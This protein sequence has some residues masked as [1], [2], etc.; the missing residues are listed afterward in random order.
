MRQI[1]PASLAMLSQSQGIEPVTLVRV[2]WTNTGSILYG[3]RKYEQVGVT[4]RLLEVGNLEDVINLTKNATTTSLS[5]KIDDTDGQLKSIMDQVDI[6]KRTVYVYQWFAGLPLSEAFVIFEGEINT[7]IV[8]KEGE[9]SLSFDVL[10]KIEYEEVGFSAEEGDFEYIPPNIIGEAWP[11]PF[12]TC[13]K[14]KSLQI[15]S[16]VSSNKSTSTDVSLSSNTDETMQS[17]LDKA[18]LCFYAALGCYEQAFQ[19]AD[20]GGVSVFNPIQAFDDEVKNNATALRDQWN[21]AGDNYTDQGNQYIAK[22]AEIGRN[23]SSGGDNSVEVSNGWSY[24]QGSDQQVTING[25][26]FTGQFSGNTFTVHG[27]NNSFATDAGLLAGPMTLSAGDVA[28]EFASNV[29]AQNLFYVIGSDSDT[30]YYVVSLFH[31]SVLGVYAQYNGITTSVPSEYY[32]ITPVTLGSIQAT[33]LTMNT[34]LS[35]ID[36]KWSDDIYCT[37]VSPVGPNAVD[38]IQYL[39]FKYSGYNIDPVTF[40]GVRA[41]L[42]AYPVNFAIT[43]RS[44]LATVLSEIAF[45]ERCAIW[46]KQGTFYLKLL[47]DPGPVAETI[48]DNDIEEGTLEVSCS[49]TE[50]LVTKY[51]AKWRA[52]GQ[53]SKDYKVIFRQNILK[54]GLVEKEDSFYIYNQETLVE[55]CS[56]FWLIRWANTWKKVK[57]SAF[58]SKLRLETF[59]CVEL[60]FLQ[61]WVAAEPV[62]GIVE[63]CN[64]NSADNRLELT[65]WVPVKFGQVHAFP[66]AFPSTLQATDVFP[67]DAETSGTDNSNAAG[68][69]Y[70]QSNTETKK[71]SRSHKDRGQLALSD[72]GFTPEVVTVLDPREVTTAAQ[73]QNAEANKYK[74]W[75]I[76]EVTK[77]TLPQDSPGSYPGIVRDQ[78]DGSFY[79]VDVYF[80]GLDG[81]P[82]STVVKQMQISTDDTI[83]NGTSCVVFKS[84]V[85]ASFDD[86]TKT[87]TYKAEYWMQVPVWLQDKKA[88]PSTAPAVPVADEGDEEPE[89]E[90]PAEEETD[91]GD[92]ILDEE[93]G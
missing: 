10:S 28:D 3:D 69:L 8:W 32:S 93:E 60:N 34:G 35:L 37:L 25:Q 84:I 27:N 55:R 90:A 31:V 82:T 24:P 1:S 92:E 75:Q 76:K 17:C 54:Y 11:L 88:T 56:L 73:K 62:V 91:E 40:I 42:A 89:E 36:S 49:D 63:T 33:I 7:P 22:A 5:I 87:G 83:P 16:L 4:G 20:D 59:D 2:L 23:S 13:I 64:F 47:A 57:F 48:T 12:G 41:K 15:N 72:T 38:V 21:D 51:T 18:K 50:E 65:V 85:Q 79:N 61:P 14:V 45:Q 70:P 52:D 6:H 74:Q 77:V 30:L 19:A 80:K 39:I 67:F 46:K 53:Q 78:S 81:E 9:R 44:S 29:G 68:T 66:W 26:T 71:T 43:S 86:I 58:L